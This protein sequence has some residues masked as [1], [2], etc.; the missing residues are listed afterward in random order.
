MVSLGDRRVD[1]S[2]VYQGVLARPLKAP[3]EPT[4]GIVLLDQQ[5]NL[6]GA[7]T[8]AGLPG[9]VE[10]PLGVN[11]RTHDLRAYLS[12]DRGFIRPRRFPL[13]SAV[14]VQVKSRRVRVGIYVESGGCSVDPEMIEP[15]LGSITAILSTQVA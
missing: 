9:E 10:M 6:L 15:D 3:A 12:Q 11:L 1:R 5:G 2:A 8:A 13:V 7:S 4:Y 14:W